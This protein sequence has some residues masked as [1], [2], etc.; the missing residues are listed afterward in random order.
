MYLIYSSD[1]KS[2]LKVI[3][4]KRAHFSECTLKRIHPPSQCPPVGAVISSPRTEVN[5]WGHLILRLL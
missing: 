4:T 5:I 2:L 3:Q 1:V